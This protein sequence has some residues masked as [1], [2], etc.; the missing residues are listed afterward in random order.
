MFLAE[1]AAHGDPCVAAA[2]ATAVVM[3]RDVA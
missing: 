3:C 1:H 2:V